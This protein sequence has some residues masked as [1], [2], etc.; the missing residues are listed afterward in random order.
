MN[1]AYNYNNGAN[2][3]PIINPLNNKLPYINY[4]DKKMMSK[5]N[6]TRDNKMNYNLNLNKI[7]T[8]PCRNYHGPNGCNRAD[9]CHFIHDQAY[10]GREIPNFNLY[11]YRNYGQNANDKRFSITNVN[12]V[13]N[14]GN[15]DE[16]IEKGEINEDMK[17][18]N[19]DNK[20]K[21]GN[22]IT[23]IAANQVNS[24]VNNN[25][26]D[27]NNFANNSVGSHVNTNPNYMHPKQYQQIN[28]YNA[29]QGNKMMMPGYHMHPHMNPQMNPSIRP[30]YMNNM[31]MNMKINMPNSMNMNQVNPMNKMNMNMNMSMTSMQNMSNH[32]N[33]SSNIG[34]KSNN[35]Q[36]M[37]MQPN[38]Y[39]YMNN[40]QRMPFNM[41]P[42]QNQVN[43]IN[44]SSYSIPSENNQ[45]K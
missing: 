16:E 11:N 18:E 42:Q 17:E 29:G 24:M 28:N 26:K 45:N 32:P 10:Q 33:N 30:P 27:Q 37:P 25:M 15:V 38:P 31:A 39:M 12:I 13:N 6:D 2:M 4:Q 9:H 1:N 44:H 14:Y 23:P 22:Y 35:P 5:P 40:Y 36:Y 3:Q 7:Y 34:N 8:K 20:V 19:L 43:N 21:D 41:M